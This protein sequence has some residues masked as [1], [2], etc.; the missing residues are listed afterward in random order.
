MNIMY[1]LPMTKGEEHG[2]PQPHVL[3]ESYYQGLLVRRYLD[4]QECMADRPCY[5]V[6][7]PDL[8]RIS[9]YEPVQEPDAVI[10]V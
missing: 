3:P 4:T 7:P 8:P 5:F 10:D 9:R 6:P 2:L 1:L